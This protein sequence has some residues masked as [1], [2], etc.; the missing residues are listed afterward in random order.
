MKQEQFDVVVVGGGGS[1]LAAAIAAREAGA[2]VVLLEKNESLGGSTAWSIGSITTTGSPH[3]QRAGIEDTPDG[4]FDDMP[5]FAPEMAQRD[6][7]TLRRILCDEVPDAFRWLLSLGVRFFGPMPEPPH[8]KP[9]MHNV[10]QNSKAYIHVLERHARRLGID[11][12]LGT[13]IGE[14]Q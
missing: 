14:G 10:L 3:Q 1:G 6:N 2:R 8:T 7:D 4:H 11:I 13:Q 12:R 9:R 5:L